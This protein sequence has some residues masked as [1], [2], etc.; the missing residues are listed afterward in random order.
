VRRQALLASAQG[1][2]A[3]DAKLAKARAAR[4]SVKPAGR[5]FYNTMITDS[6]YV[7]DD[8]EVF[9]AWLGKQ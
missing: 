9:S 6:E 5:A 3:R 1:S 2:K 8:Y 4:K 7:G